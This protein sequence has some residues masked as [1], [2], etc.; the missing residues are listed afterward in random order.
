MTDG[1]SL[2]L[3]TSGIAELL[4]LLLHFVGANE[5]VPRG[6]E[7]LDAELAGELLL[8]G[9]GGQRNQLGGC[10]KGSVHAGY[11]AAFVALVG[12]INIVVHD[13]GGDDHIKNSQSRC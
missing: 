13:L 5:L 8:A 9:V 1:R 10:G 12:G 6:N 7:S 11:R 3:H 4:D 2:H